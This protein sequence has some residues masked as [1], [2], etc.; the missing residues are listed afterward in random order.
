M[1]VILE[2]L[3]K[4]II[5]CKKCKR[6][7]SFREKI[8]SEKR[9]MYADQTYWGKPVTGFG[10][11]NAKI[12]ILGLAP[13]AHGGNRT[14]RVFTGDKSADFLFNCL[15]K[16]NFSN[17]PKSEHINDG[18]IL[19]NI[20]MTPALKCVPPFDKPTSQELSECFG[21]LKNEILELRNL[22]KILTLGQIAF[23]ACLK[24]YNLKKKDFKFSH[25]AKYEISK[26]IEIIACYH[27]SPRN[28]NTK[29]IDENKMLAVLESL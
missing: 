13:A 16:A 10:D 22:K 12:L 17:I 8:A 24:L 6:L 20:Y 21:Y 9:K 5:E 25:G 7:V 14:G 15:Y 2:K 23:N 29:R 18:L 4:K 26:K 11:L 28:V 1:S 27:P 19:K 3:N